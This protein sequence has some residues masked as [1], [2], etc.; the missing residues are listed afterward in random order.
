MSLW[1]GWTSKP[2]QGMP[3]DRTHPY[4]ANLVAA[5]VFNEGSGPPIELVNG[6]TPTSTAITWKSSVF[7]P[8]M[9]TNGTSSA[10]TAPCAATG[11]SVSVAGRTTVP[12]TP[13]NAPFSRA[14]SAGFVIG[15]SGTSTNLAIHLS[16]S[17]SNRG[18]FTTTTLVSGQW[19]SWCFTDDGINGNNQ[20]S[21]FNGVP[22][23]ASGSFAGTPTASSAAISLGTLGDTFNFVACSFD[24]IYVWNGAIPAKQALD[25]Y[26]NPWQIFAPPLPFW[27]GGGAVLL[28]PIGIASNTM[29]MSLP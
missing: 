8:A 16:G 13:A 5:W 25:I 1:T 22:Q 6:Q 4:A 21:Y 27:F 14:S 29:A 12:A 18:A 26:N 15:M 9:A 24:Y 11:V 10:V 20:A 3:I 23:T 19:F 28:D 2:P 7:G 17:G